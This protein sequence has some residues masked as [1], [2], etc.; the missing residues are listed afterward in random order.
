MWYETKEKINIWLPC[1]K[2]NKYKTKA[3]E[4]IPLYFEEWT[5][6][7][8]A[9]G[10]SMDAKL[11]NTAQIWNIENIIF[12]YDYFKMQLYFN[13]EINVKYKNETIA[14]FLDRLSC[15]YLGS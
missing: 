8:I 1:K 13:T 10:K 7:Y 2:I 12:P 4:T 5:I 6:Q 9:N 3:S 11:L 14:N 15:Q